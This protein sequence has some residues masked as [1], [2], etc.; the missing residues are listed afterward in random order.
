VGQFGRIFGIIVS[1]PPAIPDNLK[2]TLGTELNGVDCPSA[3]NCYTVG[4]SGKIY[5]TTDG[6]NNWPEKTSG[7]TQPLWEVSCPSTTSCYAVGNSGTI[8]TTSNGG[9]TW[10]PETSPVTTN[11]T[12]VDCSAG[13]CFAVGTGGAILAK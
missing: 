5:A 11:L 12:G 3:S 7:T 9:G 6:G 13:T 10:T 2:H 4:M 8:L 1:T